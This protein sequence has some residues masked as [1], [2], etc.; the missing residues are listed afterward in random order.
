MDP[1]SNVLGRSLPGSGRGTAPELSSFPALGGAESFIEVSI[2]DHRRVHASANSDPLYHIPNGS[3]RSARPAFPFFASS[4]PAGE[5][6]AR[7]RSLSNLSKRGSRCA[8]V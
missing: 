5:E 6:A 8:F 7:G 1:D 3:I 4:V 2:L